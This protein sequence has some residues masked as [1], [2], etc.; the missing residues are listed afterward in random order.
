MIL[1]A[2]DFDSNDGTQIPHGFIVHLIYL[3]S[4]LG[5]FF[6]NNNSYWNFKIII[7]IQ[8]ENQNRRAVRNEV[9]PEHVLV[10]DS[11]VPELDFNDERF[12]DEQGNQTGYYLYYITK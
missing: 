4:Y 5:Y 7:I 3:W 2:G 9:N 11:D 10:G 8:I 1:P 12:A 6:L